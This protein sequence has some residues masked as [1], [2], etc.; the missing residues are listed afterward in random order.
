MASAPILT[1][2][3]STS[4][5]KTPG[6]QPHQHTTP[7]SAGGAVAID[8]I[9]LLRAYWYFLAAA[10]FVGVGIGVAA[11]ILLGMFA[12]RYTAEAVFETK[13]AVEDSSQYGNRASG[14]G[15]TQEL[16]IYME[17][18]ARRM[19]SDTILDQVLDERNFLQTSWAG[20]FKDELGNIDRS[21]A[22]VAL[23]DIVS[24]R[25]VPDTQLIVMRA[26]APSAQ[27]AAAITNA[28][29]DVYL[30]SYARSETRELRDLI[31][32]H[33]R[34]FREVRT[35]IES[36]DTSMERLIGAN[37]LSSLDEKYSV[38]QYEVLN[39]QPAIVD[40]EVS[41]SEAESQLKEYEALLNAPGGTVYPEAIRSLVEEGPI[42]QQQEANIASQ[43]SV[44]R[45]MR[46][47][48][49]ENHREIRRVKAQIRAMELE[50]DA[51]VE[52]QMAD[53]F[54]AAVESLRQNVANGKASRAELLDKLETAKANMNQTAQVLKRHEDLQ[55]EREALL[56]QESAL[57]DEIRN[58]RLILDRPLRVRL[59]SPAKVPEERSFP[60]PLPVL[61]VSMVFTVGLV[62]GLIFLKEVREQRVRG[63]QDVA[64]IPR[65]KVLGV[66]AD[67]SLDLSDLKDAE[68]ACRDEPQGAIAESI[69]QV[70]T[71]LMK[72]CAQ[73]GYKTVLLCSGLPGSGTSTIVSNL[74]TNAAAADFKI[75]VID[76]NVRRPRMHSIFDVS[77]T[78]GLGDVLMGNAEPGEC[79]LETGTENL[80]VLCAGTRD[81][82]VYERLGTAAMQRVLD[83][84][85][86][87]YDLILIDAPPA[88]VASDAMAL[89]HLSDSAILVTR[90]FGEK[91]G[92]VARVRNQLTE[93]RTHFL[94][95]VVNAVKP[96]AG[97]YFKRNSQATHEY[98]RFVEEKKKDDAP[99]SKKEK[100]AKKPKKDKKKRKGEPEENGVEIV[101]PA[102]ADY[103]EPEPQ[104]E[105]IVTE[106][107]TD[108]TDSLAMDDAGEDIEL[109]GLD[110]DFSDD[111]LDDDNEPKI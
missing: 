100:K 33:E 14:T 40:L 65:T 98:Q 46:E 58:F 57:R 61:A 3:S 68:H 84:V 73:G 56:E 44:L 24:S 19:S 106:E 38:F 102:A 5:G 92:L 95:V 97:G 48:F 43:K 47:D 75:L 55:S 13:A 26:S 101:V 17:T 72:A 69:R 107:P 18:Q 15:G 20:Q 59:Y 22:I 53:Q 21:Q 6:P 81:P 10:G 79:I 76:A 7:A 108:E 30:Q 104:I 12:P 80:S 78:K 51:L 11:Y 66:V 35:E 87:Q 31:D 41:I 111:D 29:K 39:L 25:V 83:A 96:S 103:T 42:A 89:A 93:T 45:A 85:R 54:R 2:P 27:D 62:G 4:E 63:P 67:I 90:A 99:E 105:T 49:G 52:S 110:M 9:R 82:R 37:Q 50:R 94:G 23:R 16:E 8:P 70:R 86:D 64:L 34:S 32:E 109:D 1:T 36:I 91:R 74:A 77:N 71:A 88:V 60:R 28:V